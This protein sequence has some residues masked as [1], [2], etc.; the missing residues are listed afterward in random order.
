M[1]SRQHCPKCDAW[2]ILVR[3]DP[4]NAAVSNLHFECAK[5]DWVRSEPT[6][7][8]SRPS[9]G[10][11]IENRVDATKAQPMTS[12]VLPVSLPWSNSMTKASTMPE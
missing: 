5:C 12:T 11:K 6:L 3:V 7:E 9:G 8:L 1:P 2:M 10:W 4:I